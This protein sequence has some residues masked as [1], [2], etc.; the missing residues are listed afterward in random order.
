ML[1]LELVKVILV[2]TNNNWNL[3]FLFLC[4]QVI[5]KNSIKLCPI[6]VEN[7]C[8]I[9]KEFLHILYCCAIYIML[10]LVYNI[11]NNYLKS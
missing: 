3:K 2:G 11:Q 1:L 6:E 9:K 5:P 10:H 8:R 4:L 7:S